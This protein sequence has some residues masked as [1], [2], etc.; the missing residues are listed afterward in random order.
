MR[1]LRIAPDTAVRELDLPEPGAQSAIREHIGTSGAVDQGVYH[2]QTLLHIPG[3]GRVLGLAQNIT[4]WALASAWRGIALYPIHGPVVVT[5]RAEDGAVAALD[6]DLAQ[7]VQAVAQTVRETLAEWRSRPPASNEAAL[8][9]LL[10]Y[11]VRDVV[12]SQ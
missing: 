1:A 2:R 5:G 10:A 12:P 4:A 3:D 7:Q 6:D 11:A 9:E 8:S